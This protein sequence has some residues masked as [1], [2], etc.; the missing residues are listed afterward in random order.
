[1]F[2]EGWWSLSLEQLFS[3][4]EPKSQVSTSDQ[5]LSVVRR[6]RCC[7][8]R[9]K[10]FTFSSSSAEPLGQPQSNLAQSI[11]MW[12]GF[13][14]VQMKGA[15]L[16]QGEIITKLRKYIDKCK[17]KKLLLRT[18]GPMSTNLGTN[19]LWVKGIQVY[20]NGGFAF[21]QVEIIMKLPK[22]INEFEKL[23]SPANSLAKGFALG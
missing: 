17:K 5:K 13:K 8:C 18:T 11:L 2:L 16:F 12:R 14:F 9:R 3:S 23:S 4:P 7:C 21:F 19:H 20:S 15:A 10:L 1:M 6:R 22:Y